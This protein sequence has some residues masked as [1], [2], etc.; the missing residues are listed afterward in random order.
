MGRR[1]EFDLTFVWLL[2]ELVR[3]RDAFFMH[4]ED[5][6]YVL[7]KDCSFDFVLHQVANLATVLEE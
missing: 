1:G 6:V 3:L 4:W 2:V 5:W 7:F